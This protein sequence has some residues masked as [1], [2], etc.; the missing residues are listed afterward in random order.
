MIKAQEFFDAGQRYADRIMRAIRDDSDED[1][2]D[3]LIEMGDKGFTGAAAILWA[4]LLAAVGATPAT[5]L[6]PRLD[7]VPE[8]DRDLVFRHGRV[9]VNTAAAVSGSGDEAARMIDRWYATSNA[10]SN[11]QVWWLAWV[12]A[13]ASQPVLDS[14]GGLGQYGPLTDLVRGVWMPRAPA[15]FI[16]PAAAGLS[17]ISV[18]NREAGRLYL[19]RIGDLRDRFN[20]IMPVAAAVFLGKKGAALLSLDADG[21]PAALGRPGPDMPVE[22]R[23]LVDLVNALGRKDWDAYTDTFV[24]AVMELDLEQREIVFG[25]L[26]QT[27]G[28]HLGQ[29]LAQT[30][31]PPPALR[32]DPEGT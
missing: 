14:V 2:A 18:G 7:D 29:M 17:A 30:A 8:D 24:P 26:A 12:L 20:A 9:L 4:S 19:A 16:A 32:R 11:A 5:V 22:Q 13:H 1:Y 28:T 21:A 15:K 6:A 31:D 23:L 3:A 10:L 25:S 27:L